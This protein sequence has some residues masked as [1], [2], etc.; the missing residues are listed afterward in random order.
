[1]TVRAVLI[2]VPLVIASAG[3]AVDFTESENSL[4][5]K[6]W[7]EL[8][9]SPTTNGDHCTGDGQKLPMSVGANGID[10]EK[11][12]VHPTGLVD[13]NDPNARVKFLAV[14]ASRGVSRLLLETRVNGS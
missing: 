8:R 3:F 11:I 1:M 10:P 12:Q 9:G 6:Y 2:I 14:E 5:E 7:A 13:P 4:V